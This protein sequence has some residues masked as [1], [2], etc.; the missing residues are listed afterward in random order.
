MDAEAIGFPRYAA[1]DSLSEIEAA[2][3]KKPREQA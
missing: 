3:K 2:G 1:M